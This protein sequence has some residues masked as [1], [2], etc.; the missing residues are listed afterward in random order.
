MKTFSKKKN[1]DFA[2]T[3]LRRLDGFDWL[4]LDIVATSVSTFLPPNKV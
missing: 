4:R 1:G 2:A 3:I